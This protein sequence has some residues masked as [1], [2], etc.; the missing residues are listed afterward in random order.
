MPGAR[1]T[2]TEDAAAAADGN[3]AVAYAIMEQM[4][5]SGARERVKE[6]LFEELENAGWTAA[7]DRLAENFVT[8]RAEE[9]TADTDAASLPPPPTV[10]EISDHLLAKGFGTLALYTF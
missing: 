7:L 10:A 6:W 9:A 4:Q 2:D 3:V 8:E 5:E 1:M